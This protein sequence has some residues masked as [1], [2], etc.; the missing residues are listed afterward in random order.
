MVS[1][2]SLFN[3]ELFKEAALNANSKL[4]FGIQWQEILEDLSSGMPPA[5]D[6]SESELKARF[7]EID[8][9]GDGSLD[10]EELLTVFRN[11]GNEVTESAIAQLMHIAD[12][13]GNG[14]LEWD[15]FLALFQMLAK[16][17]SKQLDTSKVMAKDALAA[18]IATPAVPA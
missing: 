14:T 18:E 4:E 13:D 15:E 11:L 8:T 17:Q 5:A 9:S 2:S 1:S 12:D 10:E 7:D 16:V 3:E 6:L